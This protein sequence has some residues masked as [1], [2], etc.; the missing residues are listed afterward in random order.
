M[1]SSDRN[2]VICD[3]CNLKMSIDF[4]YYNVNIRPVEVLFNRRPSLSEILAIAPSRSCDLCTNCFSALSK[5]VVA[6]YSSRMHNKTGLSAFFCDLCASDIRNDYNYLVFDL[7]RVKISS[8]YY[9]VKCRAS[10]SKPE[11]NCV[12][13]SK[14][15]TRPADVQ[16]LER[17]LEINVC[18]AD[19]EWFKPVV[20]NL[21]WS[22]KS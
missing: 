12:C 6:K 1:Q 17:S 8:M 19:M 15:F 21:E 2:G 4:N 20:A 9:C 7:V 5:I 3:K 16:T 14:D 13:G 11:K 22:S 10:T 18:A